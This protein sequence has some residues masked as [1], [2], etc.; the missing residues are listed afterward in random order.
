MDT[1]GDAAQAS[2]VKQEKKQPNDTYEC[3]HEVPALQQQLQ[4][5][6]PTDGSTG[7]KMNLVLLH[8]HHQQL[9]TTQRGL[10]EGMSQVC[11]QLSTV[12]QQNCC[13]HQQLIELKRG[14]K[15][16][17]QE[18]SL[19]L[20]QLQCAHELNSAL[21]AQLHASDRT[22]PGS[23]RQQPLTLPSRTRNQDG[24][25]TKYYSQMQPP[26]I[27]PR[28]SPIPVLLEAA[29]SQEGQPHSLMNR[30]SIKTE[31]IIINPG[32][33]G[34]LALNTYSKLSLN[35]T[36]PGL[37][38]IEHPSRIGRAFATEVGTKRSAA[39]MQAWALPPAPALTLAAGKVY[40]PSAAEVQHVDVPFGYEG[41]N[42]MEGDGRFLEKTAPPLAGG[43]AL[44]GAAIEQLECEEQ[45]RHG[46]TTE[47]TIGVPGSPEQPPAMERGK[48][49][50]LPRQ[51][52]V[53]VPAGPHKH[54][55]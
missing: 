14:H 20:T 42:S 2:P 49:C 26:T 36:G 22:N 28:P 30:L 55:G 5:P 29:A 7:P 34:S 31:Q 4:Q 3:L 21:E 25:N 45:Q 1:G 47:R 53:T 52:A 40:G 27:S 19:A 23:V 48:A 10:Q 41:Q 24:A 50:Q 13:L 32:R 54:L 39:Q 16:L 38:V 11:E 17:R 9:V 33:G 43:L 18:H 46:G 35:H 15:R 12:A 6:S 51:G 8:Q 44:F 37:M